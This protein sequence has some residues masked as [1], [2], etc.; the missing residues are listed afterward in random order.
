MVVDQRNIKLLFLEA[1]QDILQI[2]TYTTTFLSIKIDKIK[3][4]ISQG[5]YREINTSLYP[6]S[7]ETL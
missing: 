2:S 3:S 5:L 4:L 1:T 6:S 7:S